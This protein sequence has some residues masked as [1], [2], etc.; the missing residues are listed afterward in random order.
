MWN[1]LWP[2]LM[3][4]AGNTFYNICAKATPGGVNAFASLIITYLTSTAITIALFFLSSGR[5]SL[6]AEIQKA[7]WTSVAFGVSLVVLE[8]G[9]IMMYRAGWDIS[10]GPMVA[11]ITLSCV[12]VVI[13]VLLYH[14]VITPTRLLGILL[15][16]IGL[17]FV[18]KK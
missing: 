13:G 9:F 16:L 3:V 12:L 5:Q 8:V 4:V 17:Y 10:V 2:V 1:Y 7:D 18:N 6:L 15:C 11:N 14:E